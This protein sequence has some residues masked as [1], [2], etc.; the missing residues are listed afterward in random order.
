MTDINGAIAAFREALGSEHVSDDPASRERYATAT[1]PTPHSVPAVI[2]PGTREDVQACLR[3]ANEFRVPVYPISTGLNTGYGSTVPA[4]DGCV[5]MELKRLDRIIEYNADLGYVTVEPGVTQEQLYAYLRERN[6][7]Y[8]LD[9]TGASPRHSMIG[10][11]AERGF[12]HTAYSDHFAHIGGMQV[13]LPQ[14]DLI[15]TGFGQYDNAKATGVYRWGV[16]PHYDGLFTQSNLG[17][18]VEATIWLMPTPAYTQFFACRID[19]DADLP[20]LIEALRPL[21]LDGTIRSAMHIGNDYKII[22]AIQS[23]PWD[24]SKGETPL[25]QDVLAAKSKEWDCGPWNAS[26]ALYGTRAEVRAARRKVKKALKG[27]VQRLQFLDQNLLWL[28][29]KVAKPY[30]WVTGVNLQEM[31][32]MLKPVFGMTQGVPSAGMLPSN[33]WRKHALPAV[34]A[35][36]SPEQDNCGVLWIAPVAPT[37]G[38]HASA[39]WDIV[40]STMLGHGYEPAVSIT[41]LTERTIDCVVNVSYDRDVPGEDERAMACHDDMLARLC[42]AGYYPYRL[43]IQTVGKM[44]RKTDAYESFFKGIREQLDPNGIL[45]PGRY[46]P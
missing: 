28:A 13:V 19:N 35:D 15:A 21:R 45:A 12:G 6:A 41:L 30:Q 18:I 27:K 36:L 33:Y 37:S 23:Y 24:A 46:L 34:S 1:F 29:E 20:V 5:V 17:V 44:P 31:M 40:R 8:W 43:G 7:P 42:E 22:S 3:I 4:A 16:G 14:G 39:I 2:R 26:G 25:P 38:V 32:K 9:V 11:I 10:N